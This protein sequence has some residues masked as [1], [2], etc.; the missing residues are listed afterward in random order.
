MLDKEKCQHGNKVKQSKTH[1]L[2]NTGRIYTITVCSSS[3]KA[4]TA[5]TRWVYIRMPSTQLPHLGQTHQY[6]LCHSTTATNTANYQE[7]IYPPAMISYYTASWEERIKLV[8]GMVE[9][10]SDDSWLFLGKLLISRQDTRS[11]D[12]P[13][14]ET[15]NGDF[16][17]NL[18]RLIHSPPSLIHN[19]P[20]LIHKPPRRT[21][22]AANWSGNA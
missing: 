1:Q 9:L 21:S 15:G 13:C 2:W 19:L 5:W 6:T 20:S 3:P 17:Y 18:S 12:L 8:E 11:S 16:F 10:V 14:W 22:R 7:A 4:K